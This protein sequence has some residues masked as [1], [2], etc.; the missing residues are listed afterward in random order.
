MKIKISPLPVKKEGVPYS[1]VKDSIRPLDLILFRGNDFVSKSIQKLSARELGPD[2][3]KYSHCG[4]IVTREI[5][6][7]PELEFNKLYI[8][9]ST[10]S[11][12]LGGNVRNIQGRAFLGCQIR[13]FDAVINSYDTPADTQVR[14]C[15][16][17][18]NPFDDAISKDN[19]EYIKLIK[20]N[21]KFCYDM[22]NGAPYTV[23]LFQL[24]AAMIPKLRSCRPRVF[25][26]TFLF[27]SELVAIIYKVIGVFNGEPANVVPADFAVADEDR[28]MDHNMF[29][30]TLITKD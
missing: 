5:L 30:H 3:R 29:E 26:H 21:L 25:M 28:Q 13:D 18:N 22:Y 8:F 17:K 11:G 16:L 9:E 24:F 20:S 27:C 7:I 15:K 14:W 4:I 6:D 19:M 1:S 23:N 10:V 2:A 12:K